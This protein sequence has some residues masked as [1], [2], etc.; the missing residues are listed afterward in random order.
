VSGKLV[1]YIKLIR[2]PGWGAYCITAVFGAITVGVLDPV[3]LAILFIIGGFVTLYGFVL[4]DY[5]DVATDNLSEDLTQRPLVK[6]SIPRSHALYISIAGVLGAYILIII[7]MIFGLFIQQ[8]NT[9]IVFTIAV[10]LAAIYNIYGKK[11]PGADVFVAG[12]TAVYCIFGALAV[13]KTITPLTWVVTIVT[14]FQVMYLNAIIG[15]LKDADH[16][17]K[18]GVKNIALTFGVKVKEKQLIIPLK[19]I[20]LALLFRTGSLIVMYYPIFFIKDGYQY[21]LWQP[22]IMGLMF[23]GVFAATIKMLSLKQFIRNDLRKL[24]SIQ[25]FLR[26]SI[27][28]VML[29]MITGYP[30]GI[31]LIFFPFLWFAIFNR[32]LYGSSSKPETL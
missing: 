8:I 7:S 30:I 26:Y 20:F 6:G 16:D 28:P 15:G 31:F 13:S 18:L 9:L 5:I 19:F 21:Q 14:F 25:A 27:V 23:I 32:L 11:F 24:I 2:L 1:E 3:L 4:N 29:L 17:Y 12:A 10:I 22:I